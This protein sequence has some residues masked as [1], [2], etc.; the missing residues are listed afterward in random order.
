MHPR[1]RG[2]KRGRPKLR[3]NLVLAFISGQA[4]YSILLVLQI[5]F[6]LIAWIG[7]KMEQRQIHNK[8]LFVPYY[9]MFMNINVMRGVLY[10][11]ANKGNGAWDKAK[12]A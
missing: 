11:A 4:F 9:F 7:Y 6:Y 8:L 10:I 12:R 1:K 2:E 3:S 5:L